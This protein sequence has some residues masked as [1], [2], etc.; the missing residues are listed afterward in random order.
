MYLHP[1]LRLKPES[2]LAEGWVSAPIVMG[3]TG[4]GNNLSSWKFRTLKCFCFPA[5]WRNCI[6]HGGT[7]RAGG[8]GSLPPEERGPCGCPSQG[9][10]STVP[11]LILLTMFSFSLKTTVE[12]IIH[13][14]P[15]LHYSVFSAVTSYDSAREM[16]RKAC[17]DP[18]GCRAQDGS[19]ALT[20]HSI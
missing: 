8:S 2:Q 15:L 16:H 18:G 17:G 20:T 9:R 13:Q 4:T 6:A 1:A 5:A 11:V 3:G 19:L 10:C 12:G 14:P 7:C